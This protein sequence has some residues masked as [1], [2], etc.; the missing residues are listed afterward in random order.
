MSDDILGRLM[1]TNDEL[2]KCVHWLLGTNNLEAAIKLLPITEAFASLLTEMAVKQ[3]EYIH[4]AEKY[5]S[6]RNPAVRSVALSGKGA[7][8][9]HKNS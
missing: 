5:H 9:F 6:L 3:S 2:L 1:R 7:P 4:G 8:G